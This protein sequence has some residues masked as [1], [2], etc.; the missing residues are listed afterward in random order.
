MLMWETCIFSNEQ[1][2]I[3]PTPST[4]IY[5][6]YPILAMVDWNDPDLEAKL[7]VL[8]IQSLYAILGLYSWEYIRSSHVEIALLR[9]QLP[10]RWPLFSYTAARFSFLIATVLL[11][12]Q[13]SPFRTSVNCQSMNS[14]TIFAKNAAIGFSTTNLMIRTWIIWKTSYL[15]RLL[16]VLF[17]LG[18]WTMLTL[19][20][21]TTH[22]STSNGVCI[23]SFV[24]RAYTSAVVIYGMLY[25]LAL[26]VLTV[27]GLL[28]MPS[29]STLWKTLVKQGVIYFILNLIANLTL[30]TLNRLS[31]NP[32]MDAV[33]ST[34]AAC[35]CTIASS[36]VVLSL[37]R[38]SV[39]FES[40]SPSS[41]KV[42]PLTSE[43]ALSG[44]QS[45]AEA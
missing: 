2:V 8:S 39:D 34:P 22:A 21:A 45:T 30:L 24:K 4:H 25:G 35:I 33:F 18:H 32:I 3:P 44:F 40:D 7:V 6:I 43:F 29:S 41:A 20:L 31:L 14:I 12:A 19:F 1:A 26:L 27:I 10:F 42:P 5:H 37:I 17:S 38:P 15:L 23:I 13:F 36:Q 11:A 16:L 9:R 28:R